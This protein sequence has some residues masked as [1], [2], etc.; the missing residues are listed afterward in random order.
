M[1]T[2]VEETWT[3]QFGLLERKP[4]QFFL[5]QDQLESVGPAL[6][7]ILRRAWQD[8]GLSGILCQENSPI[9]YFKYLPTADPETISIVHRKL[10]NQGIAPLLAIVTPTQVHVYSAL[11]LPARPQEKIE[12]GHRLVTILDRTA[13]VL[14]LRSFLRN[15]ELGEVFRRYSQS[16]DP[17]LRVDRYL[18]GNLDE[19]RRILA[20]MGL[21][22]QAVHALLTRVI[23]A[24]YLVD[25]EII[26]EQYLANVGSPKARDLRDLLSQNDGRL[27]YAFFRRLKRDF[28]GDLFD[29]N[30][31]LE[32]QSIRQSHIEVLDSFL[33][34]DRLGS[35]QLSLG[36]WAY[37]FSVIPIE[38]ISG[39]YERFLASE[40]A[41]SRH[42]K[43]I[44]YTPRFLAEAM[45]DI[46]LEG[47]RF[48]LQRRFID[49][50]CG[51]GIFLVAL[52]HRLAGEWQR[53]NKGVTNEH[54]AEALIRLLTG[55]IFGVDENPAACRISAFS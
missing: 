22:P 15:V 20:K 5:Q 33:R 29:T 6:S 1:A 50:A 36:F 34:G 31:D 26:G 8:L 37:D 11:A 13:D 17:T 40:D 32:E 27:L 28:N 4:P 38:T 55:S 52:F 30:L 41:G 49:P 51:S 25:R 35:Q 19:A 10:W 14:E 54:R 43:G 3:E 46:A 2:N 23:F 45:L 12:E 53:Q 9:L 18:L 47:D 39:I 21:A 42:S 24:C 48:L 7:Q 44:F 16:F